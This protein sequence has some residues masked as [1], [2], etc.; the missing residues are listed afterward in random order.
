MHD[1]VSA[2]AESDATGITAE[3]FADIRETMQIPL[4]T[5]IWRILAG[6][7]GALGATWEAV[8]PTFDKGQGDAAFYR[9]TSDVTW[10]VPH[11][12]IQDGDWK[13][14]VATIRAIVDAYNRSN[15][16][17]LLTLSALTAE[18]AG[19]FVA[20]PVSE[21]RRVWPGLPPLRSRDSIDDDTWALVEQIN[22]V[23]ATSDQPGVATLWRHLSYWPDLLAAVENGFAPL[24][25]DRSIARAL[26]ETQVIV[27]AEAARLA[28]LRSSAQDLPAAVRPLITQYLT[29][30]GLVMRMVV[31]GQGLAA[32]LRNGP[33][34]R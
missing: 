14:D 29:H 26:D 20:Y 11:Q 16:L 10:P 34:Q 12:P 23:G 2:L 3:V 8:K 31:I 32:W 30:P 22:L 25:R 24:Q 28:D 7:E 9:L 5:S 4:V 27:R 1:P 15:G 6:T 33:R 18:P 13:V 17:S 21:V 19:G